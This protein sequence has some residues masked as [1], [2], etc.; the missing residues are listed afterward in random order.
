MVK[1]GDGFW[2]G[3][4]GESSINRTGSIIAALVMTIAATLLLADESHQV[5]KQAV[6]KV[7]ADEPQRFIVV[8]KDQGAAAAVARRHTLKREHVY[9][10]AIRGFSVRMNRAER[11]RLA[12]DQSVALIEADVKVRACSQTIP[13][14]GR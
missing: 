10:H 4:E 8:L 3:C 5:R 11:Q 7:E 1:G 6:E 2:S 14:G 9:S 12:A 13:T